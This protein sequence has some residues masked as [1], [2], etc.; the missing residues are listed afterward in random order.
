MDQAL[1]AVRAAAI[2]PAG[3]ATRVPGRDGGA[4]E[5]V[6]VGAGDRRVRRL[7]PLPAGRLETTQRLRVRVRPREH[8]PGA[9]ERLLGAGAADR[10]MG[11]GLVGLE[12]IE[13]LYAGETVQRMP[14]LRGQDKHRID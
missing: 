8:D 6:A 1:S 2:S 13:V 12:E 4:A 11:G 9:E 5:R 10:R 3:A 14:R 7:R